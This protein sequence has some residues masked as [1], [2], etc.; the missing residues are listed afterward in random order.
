[1]GTRGC[2]CA[3]RVIVLDAP[4]CRHNGRA[5]SGS[6]TLLVLS[7]SRSHVITQHCAVDHQQRKLRI[8]TARRAGG[9]PPAARQAQPGRHQNKPL[10]PDRPEATE[11]LS[12]CLWSTTDT[13]LLAHAPL[14]SAAT[15]VISLVLSTARKISEA[16][17]TG[18][19]LI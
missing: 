1:M 4:S 14:T 11:A 6:G 7:D 3:E 13:Q 2:S 5:H 12:V 17:M 9:G 15:A 19:N 16:L 18:S 10:E 8:S